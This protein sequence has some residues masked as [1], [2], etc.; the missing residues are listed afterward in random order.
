MSGERE[1]F[2]EI[3]R[4]ARLRLVAALSRDGVRDTDARW[5]VGA[6][7]AA[8]A[9]IE[10]AQ[11]REDQRQRDLIEALTKLLAE[12]ETRL[13]SPYGPEERQALRAEVAQLAVGALPGQAERE[14]LADRLVEAV[15][16]ILEPVAAKAQ[17][18][19]RPERALVPVQPAAVSVE[20]QRRALAAGAKLAVAQAMTPAALRSMML[21]SW[22]AAGVVFAAGGAFVLLMLAMARILG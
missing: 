6:I 7:A 19:I 12:A 16:T 5:F 18:Q 13:K 11:R 21:K 1:A 8:V 15:R 2:E 10:A 9:V 20:E 22:A 14:V 4:E 3:V 17:E